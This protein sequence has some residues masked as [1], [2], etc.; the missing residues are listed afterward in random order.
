[1]AGVL[2][3]IGQET[4]TLATAIK[5]LPF[6]SFGG[7]YGSYGG[8]GYGNGSGFNGGISWGLPGSQ[9]EDSAAAGVLW[10]NPSAAACF[11]A[12]TKA[13]AQAR[14]F[15]EK[16]VKADSDQWERED[17]AITR[18][19]E[20]PNEFYS[21][22]KM[23]GVTLI[24]TMAQGRA[25]WRFER[26]K[27]GEVSEVWYEPPV[28]IGASGIAPRWDGGSFIKD[29]I[30]VVD[31]KPNLDNP[32][33]REDVVYFRHGLS[34]AN[35][36]HPWAP[37]LLGAREIAVLN[38]ASTYTAAVLRNHGAP[39]G[40]VS[41]D[42]GGLA[43]ATAPTPEQAEALKASIEAKFGGP[44]NAGKTFVSPL[45]WKWNK[46]GMTPA[47][48]V[49][50]QIRQWPQ[51]TVCALLGTPV[52]V[53]LLP[54]GGQPT[55]QNLDASMRWWWEN[56]IIPLEDSFA[57]E[58]ETQMFPAFGLDAAEYRITWDRSRVSALKDDQAALL[59]MWAS[60]YQAGGI[61]RF[62]YKT[63][64]NIETEDA[65]KG[66][67]H[68]SATPGQPDAE[69]LTPEEIAKQKRLEAATK[70]EW[71]ESA[72]PRDNDGKFGSGATHIHQSKTDG[73]IPMHLASDAEKKAAGVPPKYTDVYVPDAKD[74]PLLWKAKSEAGKI[75]QMMSAAHSE[76]ALVAKHT[77]GKTFNAEVPKLEAKWNAEISGNG[78][79]KNEALVLR[80]IHKSG[81][82]NGGEANGGK[83]A[84]YGASSLRTE[85]ATV[86]GDTIDFKFPGK[87]GHLQEHT[88]T[89]PVLAAHIKARQAAGADRIFDTN[90]GKVL[91]YLHS[92]DGQFIVHDFRTW[93][94]TA[95]AAGEVTRITS[96][97]GAPKTEKQLKS[98][99]NE[100]G[101]VAAKKIGDTVKVALSSYVDPHVFLDW[102]TGIQSGASQ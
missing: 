27:R 78:K 72:H 89:D 85:H 77:R 41:L 71:N 1:M 11:V 50:D 91:D 83:K 98:M 25:F 22:E 73:A 26:D 36:R 33:K 92:I 53:A 14:P 51:E 54:T 95:A 12:L 81:F 65:D 63:K 44:G 79:N 102:Q 90:S 18:M 29:Y 49:I 34:V 70:A 20:R 42:G 96:T 69:P 87:G 5:S 88:I 23:F 13:F 82:R 64:I 35:P 68:P 75:Q 66:L 4:K 99:V 46:V 94:A 31:G 39:A 16:R 21:G 32:L 100:V 55:Y 38:A 30:H 57:D 45:P 59:T 37:L 47:E 60:T 62:T 17:H 24:S 28:G 74:S 8:T 7:N 93:N 6:S 67:Y 52:T 9:Y 80:L 76:K 40:F 97:Q 2:A 10:E 3:R 58:I 15:L 86:R 43:S 19:L 84:A 61:D 56:T 101:K 48:M